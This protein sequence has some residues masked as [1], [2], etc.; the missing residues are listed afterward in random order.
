[1]FKNNQ[2]IYNDESSHSSYKLI[3]IIQWI[4]NNA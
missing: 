2:F 1:M 3:G 4:S